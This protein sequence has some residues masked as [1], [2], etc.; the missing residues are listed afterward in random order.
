MT[1]GAPA[2]TWLA[3]LT[4]FALVLILLAWR[5][6]GGDDPALG[7]TQPEQA[8]AT[9]ATRV[10]VRRIVKRTI[11]VTGAAPAAGGPGPAV[12]GAASGGAPVRVSSAAPAPAAAPAPP[13]PAPAPAP[14]PVT[15]SS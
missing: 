6:L 11:V 12:G 8:A 1:D 3:A 9:P 4:V 7:A 2:M 15:R 10:I 5:M 13:A 14:A